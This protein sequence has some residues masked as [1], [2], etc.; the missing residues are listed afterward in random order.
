MSKTDFSALATDIKKEREAR[1]NSTETGNIVT[2]E[3]T[4]TPPS[5]RGTTKIT[6]NIPEAAH[7]EVRIFAFRKKVTLQSMM[8][9]ALNL[10]LEKNGADYQVGDPS[11]LK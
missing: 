4:Y 9:E 1:L 5:R 2:D 8:V 11:K 3:K 6:F 7:E 10:Y